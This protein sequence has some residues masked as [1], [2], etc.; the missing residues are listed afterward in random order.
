MANPI[1][2]TAALQYTNPAQ[3]IAAK[4]LQIGGT[5]NNATFP[6]VGK[7]YKQLSCKATTTATAIDVSG[8]SSPGWMLLR[9]LD[10]TNP[11]LLSPS[12]SSSVFFARIMAG[13]AALFRLDSSV[14]SPAIVA[15]NAPVEYEAL[16]IEY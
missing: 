12:V 16:I 3:G 8:L 4:L 10:P 13:E 5:T 7:N 15:Q 6:I 1:L 2:V 11:V 9:N 14:F